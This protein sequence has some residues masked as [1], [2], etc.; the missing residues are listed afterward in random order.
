MAQVEKPISQK[1]IST[2]LDTEVPVITKLYT[3]K[4][5]ELG[6]SAIKLLLNWERKNESDNNM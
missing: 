4:E 6:L 3:D 1:P 5:I 2:C